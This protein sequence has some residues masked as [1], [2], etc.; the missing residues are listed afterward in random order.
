MRM[1]LY[2]FQTTVENLEPESGTTGYMEDGIAEGKYVIDDS[3]SWAGP[4]FW[5]AGENPSLGSNG[6]VAQMKRYNGAP[7]WFG[8][9]LIPYYQK[10]S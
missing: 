3:D 2:Y 10:R 9:A 8:H 7:W 1:K 6:S 4:S 5:I